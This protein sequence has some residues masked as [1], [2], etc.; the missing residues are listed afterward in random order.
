[1]RVRAKERE[2]K[3]ISFSVLEFTVAVL[4]IAILL[5]PRNL[6]AEF[7]PLYSVN[8]AGPMTFQQEHST[9]IE[10]VTFCKF[11]KRQTLEPIVLSR[12]NMWFSLNNPN[13]RKRERD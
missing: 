6:P 7:L 2:R 3:Q 1:M 10:T 5:K 12:S 13:L 8:W 11:I 9:H 4:C